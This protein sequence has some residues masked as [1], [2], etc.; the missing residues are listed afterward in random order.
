[1]TPIVNIDTLAIQNLPPNKRLPVWMGM[2]KAF[3]SPLKWL[4]GI[5]TQYKEGGVN[6]YWD[7]GVSY[8]IGT[9]VVYNYAVYESLVGSNIGNIPDVDLGSWL[10]VNASFIGVNE[11]R[12][13]Q[14]KKLILEYALNRY[15]AEELD[16]NGEVGFRQPDDAFNPTPSSI[17]VEDDIPD[18]LT[19]TMYP[20]A[21]QSDAMFPTYSTK[22]MTPTPIYSGASPYQFIV[23]IPT[24]VFASINSDSMI[25]DQIVTNFVNRYAVAGTFFTVQTY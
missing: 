20:D 1:M 18:L 24:A 23:W 15:F 9:R 17:Y 22:Y 4:M 16:A 13:Y 12:L 21:G 25:A 6:T 2:I 14:G 3:V 7:S 11:R 5:F 8:S 10:L 19:F